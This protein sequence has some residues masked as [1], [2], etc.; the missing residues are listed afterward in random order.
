MS[1]SMCCMWTNIV[2]RQI[3]LPKHTEQAMLRGKC[4]IQSMEEAHLVAYF[5]AKADAEQIA[6][7][8]RRVAKTLRLTASTNP[9]KS[10]APKTVKA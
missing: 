8:Q 10:V 7:V 4:C 5:L 2:G 1:P 6:E 9:V 3:C